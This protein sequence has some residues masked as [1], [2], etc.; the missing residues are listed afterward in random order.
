MDDADLRKYAGM[1]AAQLPGWSFEAAYIGLRAGFRC[2]YCGRPLLRSV[3]DYDAWQNDHVRPQSRTDPTA[4]ADYANNWALAC[5]TC[6]FI[7]RHTTP[8]GAEGVVERDAL[9]KLYRE[10]ITERRGRKQSKLHD[11][12]QWLADSGLDDGVTERGAA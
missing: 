1:M 3:E 10:V 6:N 5:K 7:K 8:N 4:A 2:E 11:I 12:R 9:V